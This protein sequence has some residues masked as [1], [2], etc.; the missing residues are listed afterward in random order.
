ME[1]TLMNQNV[2]A[3][4]KLLTIIYAY[5]LLKIF[6][7]SIVRTAITT[8]TFRGDLKL[9]YVHFESALMWLTLSSSLTLA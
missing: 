8:Y 2:T 4:G 9:Y 3:E 1:F 6:S 5:S 7:P